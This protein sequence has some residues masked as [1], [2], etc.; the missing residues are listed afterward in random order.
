M[1]KLLIRNICQP[2]NSNPYG[3]GHGGWVIT[4]MA[5]GGIYMTQLISKGNAVLVESNIKYKNPMHV[6]KFLNVYGSI[7]S[8]KQ[9][10]MVLTITAK[11]SE[12]DQKEVVV[13]SGEFSFVAIN[14]KNK[15]RKF[16]PNLKI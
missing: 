9:S 15:A 5:Q 3:T 11:R 2:K 12:M 16:K 6:G 8:V 13:A 4:Q 1:E 14:A 7:K 10:K